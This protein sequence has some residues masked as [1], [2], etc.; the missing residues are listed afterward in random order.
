MQDTL[1]RR[2]QEDSEREL[3]DLA[4]KGSSENNLRFAALTQLLR[5]RQIC[6]DPRLV[7]TGS[8]ATAN[9]SAKLDAASADPWATVGEPSGL[10][11]RFAED[12]V[13]S[14]HARG[15]VV[16]GRGAVTAP[17]PS[18]NPHEP[19]NG[20]DT[21]L[22]D[23]HAQAAT[24]TK[25]PRRSSRPISGHH[26]QNAWSQMRDQCRATGDN[27][28]DVWHTLLNREQ[29]HNP[30]AW[31]ARLVEDGTWDGYCAARGIDDYSQLKIRSDAI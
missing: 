24:K 28:W 17:E 10:A 8:K 21:G 16:S 29:A 12:G 19:S 14:F 4:A 26:L 30:A 23:R 25:T 11:G 18:L 20:Q 1:Y 2:M 9:D 31:M 27:P 5:L 13:Q 6:C 15:A 3:I 22:R 7:P